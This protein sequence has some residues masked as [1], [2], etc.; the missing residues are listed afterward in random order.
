MKKTLLA[1]AILAL[2]CACGNTN[3][4]SSSSEISS[5]ISSSTSSEKESSEIP[6]EV[7]DFTFA[8]N[9]MGALEINED[10]G[11]TI[12]KY[13]C[14]RGSTVNVVIPE[15]YKP[16]GQK[17]SYKI[18]RIAPRA[19][20]F[21]G[22]IKTIKFS[23]NIKY[24]AEGA[25]AGCSTLLAFYVDENNEV[26]SSRNDNLYS[27]DGK[28]LVCGPNGKEEVLIDSLTEEIGPSAFSNNRTKKFVIEEGVKVI[29][30]R[31]FEKTKV[32]NEI[33]LP[34]SVTTLGEFVFSNSDVD[35]LT[36]GTCIS[37]LPSYTVYQCPN[38]DSLVV[39]GNVKTIKYSAIGDNQHMVSLTL[40][41]GVETIEEYGI[42]FNTN[43]KNL[44]MPTSLRSIGA[45]SFIGSPS[46]VDV[47]I[48]EGVKSI[49]DGAFS[50]STALERL[51]IS[52]TVEEIGQGITQYCTSFEEFIV[53]E[54]NQYFTLSDS[55]LYSK[56]MKR[57]LAVPQ[58]Y[59]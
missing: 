1:F 41:E 34:N 6:T 32:A 23:K 29:K 45:C 11:I 49:G 42:S 15:E 14:K 7:T 52:S 21:A 4:S 37:V 19:F 43:L 35:S 59:G 51:T 40:N 38:L 3:S 28:T 25:F 30:D 13:T 20:V 27:K 24:C 12:T 36:L 33:T 54:N 57:L 31:A 55:S 58:H 46:L 18:T 44:S 2:L 47:V 50:H 53:S 22:G 16:L 48:P 26:Y 17:E 10:G 8:T 5:S 56:D 9:E 39:P